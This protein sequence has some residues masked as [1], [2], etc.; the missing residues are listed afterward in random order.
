[1]KSKL[2]AKDVAFIVVREIPGQ[3]GQRAVYFHAKTIG[4]ISFF[5]ELKL[6]TGVNACKVTVKSTNKQQ[7][8]LCKLSVG[9]M[10]M[11][12]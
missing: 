6:K 11:Q 4:N 12:P 10:L 3:D 9:K 2:V 1:M 8:E 7:A 5:I